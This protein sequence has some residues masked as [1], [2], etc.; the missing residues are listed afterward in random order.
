MLTV[1]TS[2]IFTGPIRILFPRAPG[3]IGE[4][5]GF[6]F[7]LLGLGDIAIPGLL[8]CLALRYDA[9]RV[10]DMR[11]RAITAGQA[12]L[13]SLAAS[14]S[15]SSST[16]IATDAADAAADAYD[17]FANREESQRARTIDGTYG[18]FPSTSSSAPS[19]PDAG[20]AAAAAASAGSEETVSE[21]VAVSD[22][23]LWQRPYFTAVSG[24]YIV[25]LLTAFAANTITHLGQ[26]ALLYIVPATLGSVIFTGLSRDELYR[27]WTYTDVATYGMPAELMKKAELLEEKKK[28]EREEA[29]EAARNN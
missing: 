18:S 21:R 22:A 29:E 20:G 5:S 13:D 23:V 17:K 28:A 25:G 24:S 6:Q 16:K 26:P 10:V 12:M 9:S 11:S 3:G 8:A 7:S 27:V 14:D 15:T 19:P 1:A 4:A 2:D